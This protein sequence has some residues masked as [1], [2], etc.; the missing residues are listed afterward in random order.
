MRRPLAYL[1]VALL[2]VLAGT[3]P[4]L[5]AAPGQGQRFLGYEVGEERRYILG[6]PESLLRGETGMWSIQ[7]DEIYTGEDGAPAG[8]FSLRHEWQAP[9]PRTEVPL[10]TIMRVASEGTVRVNAHG[11]PTKIHHETVRHLAGLGNDAY[12]IEYELKDDNRATR[13]SPPAGVTT[14]SST[15]PFAG[16]TGSIATRPPACTRSCP[17]RRAAW[18]VKCS[19]T[20]DRAAS[21]RSPA[22]RDR[23]RRC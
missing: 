6:P 14:G 17:M 8:E 22:E 19:P 12:T 18:T 16:T 9:Q 23:R 4:A 5:L 7:L 20:R 1:A 3:S 15:W 13:R 11:F 21:I 10:R 2:L